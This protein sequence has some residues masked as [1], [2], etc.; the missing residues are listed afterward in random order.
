MHDTHSFSS[1]R[2]NDGHP[3]R[4]RARPRVQRSAWEIEVERAARGIEA[5][6]AG[7]A[8]ALTMLLAFALGVT[9]AGA[10]AG[11]VLFAPTEGIP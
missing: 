7:R 2:R 5:Q 10:V 11:I 1:A 8:L 6:T 9:F 3:T 4:G